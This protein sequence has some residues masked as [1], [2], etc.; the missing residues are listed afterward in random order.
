MLGI[1]PNLGKGPPN[2][3]ITPGGELWAFQVNIRCVNKGPCAKHPSGEKVLTWMTPE[4][5]LNRV[6]VTL[7]QETVLPEFLG[8]VGNPRFDD[9]I[10]C[11]NC[12]GLV[13][14]TVQANFN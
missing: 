3:A 14:W 13:C 8:C 10:R 1:E 4:F 9:R 5:I 6:A 2:L 11:P 7:S 12:D